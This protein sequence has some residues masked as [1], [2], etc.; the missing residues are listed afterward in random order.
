MFLFASVYHILKVTLYLILIYIFYICLSF[1]FLSFAP[2]KRAEVLTK[3]LRYN[4]IPV[5]EIHILATKMPLLLRG[6][7]FGQVS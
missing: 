4:Q 2:A 5:Q 3:F 6:I 1:A 7:K